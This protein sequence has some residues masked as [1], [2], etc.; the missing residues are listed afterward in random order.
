MPPHEAPGAA[1]DHDLFCLKCAYNLRG[2]SGDPV[3]CP[4]CGNLNPLGE[5]EIPAAMIATRL[6]QMETAPCTCVGAVLFG[7]PV[8]FFAG[9]I[10]FEAARSTGAIDGC[11]MI[12][13]LLALVAPVIWAVGASSFRT[14]CAAKPGWFGL[15][16]LYHALGLGAGAPL[17]FAPILMMWRWPTARYPAPPWAAGLVAVCGAVLLVGIVVGVLRL[18]RLVMERMHILQREVAVHLL[19]EQSRRRVAGF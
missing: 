14:S 5:A 3:R 10:I 2:L 8:V 13:V 4:E 17:V 6:R 12:P 19:R 9:Y 7:T 1:L 15:L 16:M 18:Y 11:F